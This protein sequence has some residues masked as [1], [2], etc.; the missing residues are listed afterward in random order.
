MM[1]DLSRRTKRRIAEGA[2]A[3][4]VLFVCLLPL[5]LHA[6]APNPV[7]VTG[8]HCDGGYGV[9]ALRF[10][11]PKAGTYTIIWDNAKVCGVGV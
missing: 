1:F 9:D 8:H 6:D 4:L 10:E 7:R 5:A 3:A 11:V 2:I